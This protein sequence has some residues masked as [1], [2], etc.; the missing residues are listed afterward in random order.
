MNNWD[1]YWI[2]YGWS[3][4]LFGC[5]LLI[6]LTGMLTTYYK[7]IEMQMSDMVMLHKSKNLEGEDIYVGAYGPH[8]LLDCHGCDVSK[9]NRKSIRKF[10]LNLTKGIGMDAEDFYFW[11]D[12]DVPEELKR[13]EVHAKGTSMGGVIKKQVGV[14]FIIT[15]S[16]VIHTI[17]LLGRIYVDIFSCKL[18]DE[19]KA[20][21]IVR[22][23]FKA[24][25]IR[26]HLIQRF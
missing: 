15:S 12:E 17:D 7:D 22:K 6:G 10:M 25:S 11:D 18:F 16:I 8:L 13:T 14:Q 23:C 1:K 9:F 2:D 26:A 4:S 21:T 24:T 19:W 20:T 5:I 3:I